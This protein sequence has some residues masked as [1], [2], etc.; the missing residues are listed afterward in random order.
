MSAFLRVGRDAGESQAQY[1][2][3][4]SSIFRELRISS[5]CCSTEAWLRRLVSWCT[6]VARH[7]DIPISRL[8]NVQGDRWLENRRASF[9]DRPACQES[10]GFVSRWAEGWWA[11]VG[12]TEG[13]GWRVRKGDKIEESR[14]V[15]VIR[16][17]IFGANAAIE[18]GVEVPGLLAICAPLDN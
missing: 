7:A 15:D 4:R 2:K 10:S 13:F 11:W 16:V 18:D 8:L 17:L 9:N 12:E 14:R 6:H 1:F 3:R 5:D